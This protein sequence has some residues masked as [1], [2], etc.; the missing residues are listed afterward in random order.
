MYI[1]TSKFDLHKYLA[2]LSS[3]KT[4]GFV[5]TM[6][7]LHEGHLE[8]IKQSKRKC[9][10]TICSIFVNPTQF[11]NAKD[12]ASY[13]NHLQADLEQ[14]EQLGCDIVYTPTVADVYQKGEKS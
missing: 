2:T 7:G 13:P 3:E 5:P 1:F 9:H 11:N 14:L 8:L 12:L 10:T 4:V 6:G